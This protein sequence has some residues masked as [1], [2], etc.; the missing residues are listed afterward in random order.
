VAKARGDHLSVHFKN[1]VEV[2]NAVKGMTLERAQSYLDAV[3]DKKEAIPI[4][5]SKGGRGRHAQS[6]NTRTPGSLVF[7][8][9]NATKIV[10]VRQRRTR[11]GVGGGGVV[12][13][14]QP[15]HQPPL[16]LPHSARARA[17]D[18]LTNAAANADVKG[19]DRTKLFVTHAQANQARKGRRRTYRAHGRINAYMSVPAHVELMLTERA[20]KAARPAKAAQE[21]SVP[22]LFKK[23]TAARFRIRTGGGA[24]GAGAA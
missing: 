5:I 22:R 10:K 11:R 23:K 24:A 1:V 20:D 8:P 21:K 15:T 12:R 18:L 6:K 3:L 2:A 13:V 17:Q 19:L 16:S 4:T 9:R 7:W 14:V